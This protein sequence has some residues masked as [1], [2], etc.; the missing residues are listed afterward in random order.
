MEVLVCLAAFSKKKFN[1]TLRGVTHGHGHPN[2]SRMFYEI[3]STS[4][5]VILDR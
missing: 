3:G 5:S 4:A 2:V 1:I